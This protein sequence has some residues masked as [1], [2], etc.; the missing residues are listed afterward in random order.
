[1]A[2]ANPDKFVVVSEPEYSS[3]RQLLLSR[4][5]SHVVP[6]GKTT[7]EPPGEDEKQAAPSCGALMPLRAHPAL[8]RGLKSNKPVRAFLSYYAGTSGGANTAFQ[9]TF[10]L[11][12]N[13]DSSWS[14]WQAVFDEVRVVSAELMWNVYMTTVQSANPANAPNAIAVYDPASNVAIA[15]VNSAMQF[16]KFDLMRIQLPNASGFLVTPQNVAKGG[17]QRFSAKVP[18]GPMLSN[19]VTTNSPGLWRP[20]GDAVQYDWG[21]FLVYCSAAGT[22]CVLRVEAFVRMQCEFRVRR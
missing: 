8:T 19:T 15:N 2:D 5:E 9:A 13:Q 16:E 20:T 4:H 18:S 1:M 21:S 12:P 17:Y 11:A 14:S 6:P 7:K 3:L 22:S 10:G